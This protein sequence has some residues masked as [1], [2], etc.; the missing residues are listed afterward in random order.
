MK[1][2]VDEANAAVTKLK[3]SV[4][5]I[6]KKVKEEFTASKTETG[7]NIEG[8]NKEIVSIKEKLDSQPKAE[9]KAEPVAEV[10]KSEPVNNEELSNLKKE[11]EETKVTLD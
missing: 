7:A 9:T 10:P 4:Q 6:L 11:A 8:I 3:E 2:K 1:A 5:G